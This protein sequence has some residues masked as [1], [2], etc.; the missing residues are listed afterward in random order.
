[1]GKKVIYQAQPNQLIQWRLPQVV[2]AVILILFLIWLPQPV[3]NSAQPSVPIRVQKT[4]IRLETPPLL[5]INATTTK[6]PELTAQAVYVIDPESQ[7][8]LY[9]KNATA[10][11]PPASTT[12]LMTALVAIETYPLEQIITITQED[13]SIGQTMKVVAGEQLTVKDL[14][15][16]IL[17]N[18]A[19]DAA[20]AL[21]LAYPNSGYTGFVRAMN[22]KAAEL[23]LTDTQFRNVSGVESMG[24]YSSAR[25]L[26][27]LTMEAVKHPLI[28]QL[29]AVSQM[30][31]VSID[32]TISH[33]LYSTNQLLPVVEGI[34]GV[35]TGWTEMAGECLIAKVVRDQ[36]SVITVVLG[37]KDRFGET[38]QLI[39]WVY[40]SHIW[41]APES[42]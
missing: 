14:L 2:T 19:N 8:V 34:V 3:N 23:G 39:D 22:Q 21:A 42:L 17:V 38:Q 28:S 25:D 1:M 24:H 20:L 11:L 37:S 32:G 41:T 26:A 40:Q 30:S 5:P 12:K 33:N 13:R 27:I 36:G 4:A 6:P 16:G 31:V 18:S 35:K 15:A 29:V 10:P 9:Q 7:V